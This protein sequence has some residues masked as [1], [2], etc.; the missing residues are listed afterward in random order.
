MTKEDAVIKAGGQA[1]FLNPPTHPEHNFHVV[2]V[3]RDCFSIGLFS[4][5]KAD[6]IV[7]NVRERAKEMLDE[8]EANKPALKDDNVQ[9]WIH[10]VLG[11]FN[12]CYSP[13]GINRNVSDCNIIK[14][15]PF[16]IGVKKHLGVLLVK[17]YYP[18]YKPKA[19]DFL[20]AYWSKK[21]EKL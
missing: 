17:K 2:S 16:K 13:D 3:R 21:P 7:D 5:A 1:G 15:S 4:A 9:D 11:Y 20:N 19:M 14:G 8:W 18:E 12:N 10:Q 6:W